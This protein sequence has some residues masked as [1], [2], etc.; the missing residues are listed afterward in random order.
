[1]CRGVLHGRDDGRDEEVEAG[2]RKV[3]ERK[4]CLLTLSQLMKV[5]WIQGTGASLI[6]KSS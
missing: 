2:E 4:V 3:I 5:R 6:N 1:M